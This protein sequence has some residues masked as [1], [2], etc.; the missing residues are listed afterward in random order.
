MFILIARRSSGYLPK[1]I[2]TSAAGCLSVGLSGA[3]KL[4]MHVC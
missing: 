1:L 4:V 2:E 3:C